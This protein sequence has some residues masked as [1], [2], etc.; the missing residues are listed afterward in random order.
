[1]III[2]FSSLET[3]YWGLSEAFILISQAKLSIGVDT[4]L[5]HLSSVLLKPT[6]EL[7][8]DTHKWK[9]ESFWHLNIHNLGDKGRA[10]HFNEVKNV[11]E[12]L[13]S[14]LD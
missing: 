6:I 3:H 4:G 12:N 9:Y 13:L 1:L 8:V 7:Y 11:I 2:F 10:P 14:Q 5:T